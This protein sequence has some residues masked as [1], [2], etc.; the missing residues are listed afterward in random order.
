MKCPRLR[1]CF[2]I[3][4]VQKYCRGVWSRLEV[5]RPAVLLS[6]LVWVSSV[7]PCS[8]SRF[9]RAMPWLAIGWQLLLAY[10]HAGAGGIYHIA[11]P[12]N[13][14]HNRT[15]RA[16]CRYLAGNDQTRIIPSLHPV[17]SSN[18]PGLF[19]VLSVTPWRFVG[20]RICPSKFQKRDFPLIGRHAD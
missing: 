6:F 2:R 1:L 4:V 5:H 18:L 15:C 19:A 13:L 16:D 10:R 9:G 8:C 14:L 12:V 20:S 11:K 7:A 3:L 17:I